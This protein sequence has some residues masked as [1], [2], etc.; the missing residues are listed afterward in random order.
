MS[1]RYQDILSQTLQITED[2]GRQYGPLLPMATRAAALASI[3]LNKTLSAYDVMVIMSCI[4]HSRISFDP[5]KED[6]WVDSIAYDSFAAQIALSKDNG[7]LSSDLREVV[8][9]QVENDLKETFFGAGSQDFP[10]SD[11]KK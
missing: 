1:T 8:L 2:R 5:T 7:P 9:A 10:S 4:K 6:S 3:R 11:G